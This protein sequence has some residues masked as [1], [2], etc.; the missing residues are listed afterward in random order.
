MLERTIV[1][2]TAILAN[3]N[4]SNEKANFYLIF[5]IYKLIT[6][7]MKV[8]VKCSSKT[9]KTKYVLKVFDIERKI[10]SFHVSIS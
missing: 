8:F 1:P 10:Y 7:V 2:W 5:G 4:W 6:R 9:K 3:K